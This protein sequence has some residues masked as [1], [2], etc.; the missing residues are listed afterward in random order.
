M[1]LATPSMRYLGVALMLCLLGC[2]QANAPANAQ[3][4]PAG[5]AP[6]TA[7]STPAESQSTYKPEVG[8]A[9]KDVVWV[10]TP[11]ALVDR[12]LDM[13]KLTPA[14][15]L[16]DLGSGDG[17]T[18][19]TAAKRGANARG[20]EYNQDM[21]ALAMQRAREAGVTDRASFQ[22]ADI[23][24]TDFSD[25][26]VVTL[27][28]LPALN[29][30]LRPTILEM[31]PGTRVVSNT[32]DMGEWQADQIDEVKEG[33]TSYCT[34][35]LWIVPA[36]VEGSWSL[37]DGRTLKLDQTFQMLSGALGNTAISEGRM[38]GSEI[39]FNLGNDRYV[40]QI[41]GNRIQGTVNGKP[42]SATRR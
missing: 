18:V 30:R 15:R 17:V 25:A 36:Q 13:A 3:P 19:I 26:T 29:Q 5:A 24:K 32:F 33:C 7:T 28:L 37:A 20:I 34:A 10:P 39:G 41:D 27:F 1:N 2:R 4:L 35:L 22:Q 9:G 8:Q 11:Q 40:G 38:N 31:K 6:Q 12:M 16:V 23:F 14:D 21:V 42:W